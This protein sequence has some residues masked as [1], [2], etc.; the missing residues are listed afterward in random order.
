MKPSLWRRLAVF[1][2]GAAL[3]AGLGCASSPPLKYYTLSPMP[4]T[5]EAKVGKEA[6]GRLLVVGVGPIHL[7]NYL[8]RKEIVTRSD[9]YRIDLAENDLWGGSLQDDF[10]RTLLEN[11]TVLLAEDGITLHSWPGGGRGD[12]RVAVDVI[13]FDGSPGKDVVLVTKCVIRNAQDGTE[14]RVRNFRIQEPLKEQ[15]YE[16]MVGGMSRAVGR[17]S[18]EIGEDLK[19]LP[20]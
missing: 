4:V 15:G 11:L 10:S 17:L 16:A 1:L 3:I 13:R 8:T 19:A 7:P 2:L 9:A 14:V 6:A 12:Y 18:R 5:G 20:R